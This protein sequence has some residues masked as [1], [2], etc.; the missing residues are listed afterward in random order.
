VPSAVTGRFYKLCLIEDIFS[1]FPV[2]RKV[3]K[4]ET[5]ELAAELV[6]RSVLAQRCAF[7]SLVL[8]SL[9]G[10]EPPKAKF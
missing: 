5:G 8:S 10:R 7:S 2:D 6:Q 3:H 9:L 1:R 4:E